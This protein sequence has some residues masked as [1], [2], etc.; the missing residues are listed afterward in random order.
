MDFSSKEIIETES[1]GQNLKI[2]PQMRKGQMD[3]VCKSR[4]INCESLDI[5]LKEIYEL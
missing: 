2:S 5:S 3:S 1:G 4:A